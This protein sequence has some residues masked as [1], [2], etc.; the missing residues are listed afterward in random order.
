[1]ERMYQAY[2]EKVNFRLVY[3]S[4]A[5]A[6]DDKFPVPYASELGIREHKNFGERC[7]VASRLRK[8]KKLTIPCLVDDMN[9]TVE[10]QYRAWPDKVFLVRRDGRLAVASKRGPWG[11]KPALKKVD[12]WLIEFKETG[13]E[14]KLVLPSDDDVDMGEWQSDFSR[15]YSAKNYTKALDIGLRIHK[16]DQHDAGMQYNIACV[17]SLIGDTDSAIQWLGK[18]IQAGYQDADHLAKD[19]DF[20]NVRQD[21]RFQEILTELRMDRKN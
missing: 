7:K 19:E 9:N 5:H 21:K 14:P 17:Y 20:I 4:E 15:A 1:M 18:A 11:F 10:K 2:K 16:Y 6:M 12:D 13:R 3:I 8:D